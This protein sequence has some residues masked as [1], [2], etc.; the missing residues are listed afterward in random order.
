M[1]EDLICPD[2]GG[3][4]TRSEASYFCTECC[5]CSCEYTA[6]ENRKPSRL[7]G[8]YRRANSYFLRL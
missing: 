6:F 4:L 1:Y 7:R 5:W 2:C 8:Q 3:K